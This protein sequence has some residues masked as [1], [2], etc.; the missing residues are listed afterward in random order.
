MVYCPL[1]LVGDEGG[2]IVQYDESTVLQKENVRL[3]RVLRPFS[4][5]CVLSSLI[6][7]PMRVHILVDHGITMIASECNVL[8]ESVDCAHFFEATETVGAESDRCT[9]LPSIYPSNLSK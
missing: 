6:K 8:G 9:D 7:K 4:N 3:V 1:K 2:N 5:V